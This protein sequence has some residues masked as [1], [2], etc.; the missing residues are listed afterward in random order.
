VLWNQAVHTD[1][2]VTANEPNIINTKRG[3]T[4]ILIEVTIPADRNVMQKKAEKK[5]NARVYV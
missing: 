4:S 2:E 3:K 5:L 1:T